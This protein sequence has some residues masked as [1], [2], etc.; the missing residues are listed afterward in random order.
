[1]FYPTYQ[2]KEKKICDWDFIA[3]SAWDTP[4]L[5][6]YFPLVHVPLFLLCKKPLQDFNSVSLEIKISRVTSKP[7]EESSIKC[8]PCVLWNNAYL[9]ENVGAG[10]VCSNSQNTGLAHRANSPSSVTSGTSA[11]RLLC[12]SAAS[13]R[14]AF[15]PLSCLAPI[16]KLYSSCSEKNSY[17]RV[18]TPQQQ[19]LR[20]SISLTDTNQMLSEVPINCKAHL[21]TKPTTSE[22]TFVSISSVTKKPKPV[23]TG[24][25]NLVTSPTLNPFI[26]MEKRILQYST[27]NFSIF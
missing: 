24:I 27:N 11:Y 17:K 22:Q 9:E 13:G 16:A 7:T 10:E 18:S 25:W 2:D 14:K 4:I 20:C 21:L 6:N 5:S 8:S 1:M 26:H 23:L 12:N 19:L 3:Y 15:N